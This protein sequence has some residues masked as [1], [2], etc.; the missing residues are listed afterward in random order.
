MKKFAV[1]FAVLFVAFVVNAFAVSES[2]TG[3]VT[4]TVITPISCS[5]ATLNLGKLAP[6][7]TKTGTWNLV[8]TITGD[9]DINYDMSAI[10]EST[11]QDEITV[12]FTSTAARIDQDMPVAG[13]TTETYVITSVTAD[14]SAAVRDHTLTFSTTASYNY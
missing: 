1:I 12:V 3:T 11:T 10:T 9:G 14:G 13:T 5:D 4:C 2:G 8:F 6:G 7:D